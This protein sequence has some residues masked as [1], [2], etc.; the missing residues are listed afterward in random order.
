MLNSD[1]EFE[2]A[3]E[4]ADWMFKNDKQDA[5]YFWLLGQKAANEKAI[6]NCQQARQQVEEAKECLK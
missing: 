5:K 3:W 4:G 6:A 2:R 1:D